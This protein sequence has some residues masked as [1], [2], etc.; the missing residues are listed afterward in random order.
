MPSRYIIREFAENQY[1]HVFNRGNHKQPIFKEDQ[2]YRVFLRLFWDLIKHP[3]PDPKRPPDVIVLCYCLMPNHF[4]L[5]LK[6]TSTAGITNLMKRLII[7]YVMYFNKKYQ[8]VGKLFQSIFKAKEIDTEPYLLHL[9]RYIH[10]NPSEIWT[11]SL[12]NYPYS[13]YGHYLGKTTQLPLNTQEILSFFALSQKLS[14]KDFLSYQ[15][16]VESSPD[17]GT[18]LEYE[19]LG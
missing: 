8:Q 4:H 3:Y 19:Y 6:Q 9:T 10:Q 16:F 18:T 13:S 5:L 1:Y 14:L 2:D 17:Q 12:A 11:G 15:S 7:K